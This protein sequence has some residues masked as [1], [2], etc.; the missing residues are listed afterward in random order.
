MSLASTTDDDRDLNVFATWQAPASGEFGVGCLG[1][2]RV[3]IDDAAGSGADVAGALVVLTAVLGF[4]G[5]ALCCSGGYARSTAYTTSMPTAT[6]A[7]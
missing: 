2:D 6:K 7:A 1:L 5:V 3:F 4:A